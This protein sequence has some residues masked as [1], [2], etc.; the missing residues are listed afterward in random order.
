[1]VKLVNEISCPECSSKRVV[2]YKNSIAICRNCY[3]IV[4]NNKDKHTN[5]LELVSS[6]VPSYNR[7]S[8]GK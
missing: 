7:I 5:V 3:F 8:E 6:Y 1:M 4:N 2:F